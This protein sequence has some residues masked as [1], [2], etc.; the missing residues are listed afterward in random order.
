MGR[1]LKLAVTGL[2]VGLLLSGCANDKFSDLDEFMDEKRASPGGVIPP[3][4][5]FK[6]YKAFSYSATSLRSPF[7]RPIEIREITQLQAVSTVQPDDMRPKEFLEQFTFDSLGMVGSLSRA[8]VD[9][10]LIRD[11]DG[12]VHRV[13]LGNFLGRNHGR[14]VEM[15]ETY[16]AVIE[17]VSD[18]NDGWVE[19][20][21]AIKLLN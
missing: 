18:G 2:L 10:T 21:R 7:D 14:I 11:P 5:A 13:K 16:V 19:R 3:I 15:T 17:I 8:G 1:A 9:W 20:P 4:P 6:A 12:G